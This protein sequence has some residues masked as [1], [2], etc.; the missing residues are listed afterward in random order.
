MLGDKL[1]IPA[2]SKLLS[3]D[4]KPTGHL[5]FKAARDVALSAGPK[6]VLVFDD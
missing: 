3:V 4:G 5:D 6:S 1:T 2:G